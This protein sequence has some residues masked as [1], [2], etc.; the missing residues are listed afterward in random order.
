MN[1]CSAHEPAEEHQDRLRDIFS[2]IRTPELLRA[3]A[4]RL[5]DWIVRGDLVIRIG[6]VYQPTE[7]ARAHADMESRAATGKLLLVP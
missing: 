3:R 6:G 2:H 4:T 1:P 7:A 5:F